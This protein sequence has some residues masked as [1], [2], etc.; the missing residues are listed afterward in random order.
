[1]FLVLIGLLKGKTGAQIAQ[2]FHDVHTTL[3]HAHVHR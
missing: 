2:S 3:S 1:M